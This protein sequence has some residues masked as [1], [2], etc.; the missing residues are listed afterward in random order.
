MDKLRVDPRKCLHGRHRDYQEHPCQDVC[1]NKAIH[2]SPLEIDH[3]LCDDCGICAGVCPAGALSVKGGFLAEAASQAASDSGEE[4]RIRCSRAGERCT[5]VACL[6]ALDYAFLAG[7]CIKGSKDLRLLARDC[8]GCQKV[9]GGELARAVVN[10]ANGIL[11]LYGR[12]ERVVLAESADRQDLE[13]GSKRA[14]FRGM[15]R[16][17]KRLI[18]EMDQA[19]HTTRDKGPIP[20][21]LTRAIK[22]IEG[23]EKGHTRTAHDMPL[24]FNGKKIDA[25]RCDA[26]S[27]IP[28]CVRFCPTDA[29]EFSADGDGVSI[30]FNSGRC[31]GCG[32]CQTACGEHAVSSYPLLSGQIEELRR[33]RSLVCFEVKECEGC[34][35]TGMGISDGFCQDCRQRM[36]KLAW[37]SVG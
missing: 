23:L 15:G 17:I 24:P 35:R 20:A 34:G 12:K 3:G 30:V 26:C 36:R 9:P 27:G 10:T 29:L 2:L 4:L 6:G 13:S 18:P 21:R 22:L 8:E 11:S 31:I 16:T 33:P 25:D 37:E 19:G 1:P 5:S 7:L 14:M 28:K 32:L